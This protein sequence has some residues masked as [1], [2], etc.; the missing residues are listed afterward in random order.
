MSLCECGCGQEIIAKP[1]HKW[2]GTPRFL[3]GH[4]ILINNPMKDPKVAIK[5]SGEN[6]PA[7]RPEVRKRQSKLQLGEKNSAYGK[8]WTL[9]EET[10][11]KQG[12]AKSGIP[13]QSE[14]KRK[15][16]ASVSL[17]WKD[18]TFADMVQNAMNQ[19]DVLLKYSGENNVWWRGGASNLPYPLGFNEK[20]K[21]QIR[22]RDNYHCR[23]CSIP[24]CELL[25]ALDV[26]H[27]D[28]DKENLEPDNLISLCSPCNIKCNSS[29]FVPEF[30]SV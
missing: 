12:I 22:S 19:P 15:I 23:L 10:K 24:Q 6:N 8:H 30:L 3:L 7:K 20:L 18:S 4:H 25:R 26:H 13:K 9:T 17:L 5:F 14:H 2:Y 21:E 1:H 28:H 29:T 27:I 11:K 16:G